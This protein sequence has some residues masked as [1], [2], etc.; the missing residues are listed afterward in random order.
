MLPNL[1]ATD[2]DGRKDS[3]VG[4]QRVFTLFRRVFT[5]A[6]V[7]FGLDKLSEFLH[8][9]ERHL[10]PWINDVIPGA[11]NAHQTML[12]VG[13]IEVLAGV[14][15]AIVPHFLGHRAQAFIDPAVDLVSNALTRILS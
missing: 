13:I 6:P 12:T 7:A 2:S 11:G 9:W 5:I 15:V 8:D 10:G 3:N 14:A 4:A 1:N